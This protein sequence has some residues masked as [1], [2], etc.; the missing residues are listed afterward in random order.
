MGPSQ[1]QLSDSI[2]GYADYY[3]SF[4]YTYS[5][6]Y[7]YLSWP[8]STLTGITTYD[9]NWVV[10]DS[11]SG[12][13][14][15][16]GVYESYALNNDAVGLV[17][18]FFAGNDTFIG[19]SFNDVLWSYAGNDTIDGGVGADTLVGGV[20][21]DTYVVDNAGDVVTENLNEGADTVQSSLSYTLGANVEN[22]AL[23]GA[24]A[25]D[26]TGNALGNVLSGNDAANL[27]D[28]GLGS[29]SMSGGLG[30][31]TY[32]VDVLGDS[33]VEAL[34]QG[35]DT[36]QS[37]IAYTLGTNVENL[38]LTGGAAINGT[39]NADG[40]I[41]TGNAADNTLDGGDGNDTLIG[42]AGNDTL[43][44]G[45]GEDTF[46]GGAG[47]DTYV[48][49]A[50]P[51]AT[52]LTVS[53][54]PEGAPTY[55]FTSATGSWMANVVYYGNGFVDY[56]SLFYSGST[57]GEFFS[58]DFAT[59]MLGT[60]LAPGTYL[61]A[62][63]AAF[64]S[65]GHPGLD[66]GLNGSGYNT[67]SGSFSIQSIDVDYSGV[68]PVLRSLSATFSVGS[69]PAQPE[70]YGSLRYNIPVSTL[71]EQ[72]TE[73][74]NEGTDH[75]IS[76]VSYA[77]SDNVE[78][79][80]LSG[81]AAIDGIGNTLDNVL[82][83]NSN[84]NIFTGGGGNDV[85]VFADSG[86]GLD[87]ITDFAAGDS[88]S[89]AGAAFSGVVAAGDGTAVLANQVQFSSAGGTTTLYIGTDAVAGADVQLQ[90]AGTFSASDFSLSGDRIYMNTLPTG[91]VS[92]AGAAFRGYTLTASNTLADADGLGTISYQWQADGIDIAGATGST[93]VP[94]Q[95]DI[96]K[97]VSVVA[98]YVDARGAVES[99][100]SNGVRV[101]SPPSSKYYLTSS[102]GSN[103]LDFD[104]AYGALSLAGQEYVFSG[105]T[106]VDS[107]FIRPGIVF[108]F[109]GSAASADKLYLTGN[110]IDYAMSLVGT[111]M[112][113]TR[114]VNQQVET[115][116]VSRLTSVANSDKLVFAD[117]TVSTFD[118]Y[119]HLNSPTTVSAPVPA[120]ETSA[121][122]TLPAT[123]NAT[124]KAYAVDSAGETFAPVNP[125]MN[126]AAIGSAGVDIVYVK[127]GSNV[128]A[129]ALGGGFDKVY[130]TGNWADYT[131]S[132][133]GTNVVFER[134]VG[135]DLEYVKVA[136]ATGSS[137]DVLVF[138]D[139][140]VRSNDAKIALQSDT[141]IAGMAIT[142]ATFGTATGWQGGWGLSEITPLG[143]GAI[144]TGTTATDI[145]NGTAAGEVI[146]GNGGA[147]TITGGAGND[148][149]VI[150]DATAASSAT[151]RLT[152]VADGTDTVIG[153]SAAPVASG[154][155]VLDLSA[156]ANL[157]DAVAIG[158]TL[159]T[160]FAAANVFIFDATPVAIADAANAIAADVSVI[161]TDGY[162]VIADSANAN[163]VTVFHSTDLAANGTETV[164]AILS[165][166]NIVQLS[167][168][169]I[170]V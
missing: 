149:I 18:Y 114:T 7:Q 60:D 27:L 30:N 112:T 164:L 130:L 119:A 81:T 25:I 138:A 102:P 137:N 29:D 87:T 73:L 44:G 95:T 101:A 36:I 9:L 40:N 50:T 96:G 116:K 99:V 86:N 34:N 8:D 68:I 65:P 159:T 49:D 62:E 106:S 84:N 117:G 79:L 22:L 123:L 160:D 145:L 5:G 77:L 74:A 133:A 48:V 136:A 58:L 53:Y 163:A 109:T 122:P 75:V 128:D 61:N 169:N 125:G 161:A 19:S 142:T 103:L 167:A 37:A 131:K 4:S 153:F 108:D 47:D 121:S 157:T 113:L 59:N 70:K 41:L 2:L 107:V 148:Q 13:S 38:T 141:N 154:G 72:V 1:F 143:T 162:I 92:I 100:A 3:G 155:D 24:A 54:V 166:V 32:V 35:V 120:G 80:T 165:G 26:G 78:N 126:L 129:S 20:G 71:G 90:L 46:T 10:Q 127:A 152:S 97:S 64:A 55:T 93:Y 124:V 168:G 135:A 139:G 52:V 85:F 33:V 88:I 16:G 91:S 115:V 67:L 12:L 144:V 118:L 17:A 21:D 150:A 83:G 132:I 56:L 14:I 63:R 76:S 39:G 15:P 111:V 146:Y 94:T 69:F 6:G 42:G 104:L 110:Y 89:V 134:A 11:I 151:V 28:G 147:D 156:I 51:S 82:T 105:T 158:Q 170:L 66:F 57:L 45:L 23:T 98:G 31:D 43:I 140:T